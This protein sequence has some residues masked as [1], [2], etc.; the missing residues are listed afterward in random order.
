MT[1]LITSFYSNST[2]A[3]LADDSKFYRA[4]DMPDDQSLLQNDLVS[5]HNWSQDWAM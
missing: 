5:F 2:I 4:M 1:Y 3:L